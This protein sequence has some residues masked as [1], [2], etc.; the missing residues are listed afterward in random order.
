MFQYNTAEKA[1][2]PPTFACA[3]E[4]FFVDWENGA[5]LGENFIGR[6]HSHPPVKS[7]HQLRSHSACLFSINSTRNSAKPSRLPKARC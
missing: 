3:A 7:N 5:T 6:R 4:K 1:L 2:R